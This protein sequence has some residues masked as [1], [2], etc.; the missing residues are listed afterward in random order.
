MK[1]KIAIFNDRTTPMTLRVL[2]QNTLNSDD[3]GTWH[4]L[5]PADMRIVEIE[6]PEGTIPFLK[7]WE[8]GAALLTYMPENK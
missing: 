4:S 8:T 6:I 5:S 1:T 2:D 3:M 7:I